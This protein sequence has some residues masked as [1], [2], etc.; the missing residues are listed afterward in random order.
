MHS[1]H[2]RDR[3]LTVFGRKPVLEALR[4][5]N[6]DVHQLLLARTA[7]GDFVEQILSAAR[8]RGLKVRRADPKQVSKLSRHPKQDQG[9]AMDVVAQHMRSLEQWLA[10]GSA[11][12]GTLLLLD[13]LTTPANIG[14]LLR[15]AVAVGID[16]IIIPRAGSPEVGPLVIKASAGL[17]FRAPILRCTTSHAAAAALSDAGW[18]LIGLRGEGAEDLYA[19][20]FSGPTVWV[21]GNE[22]HGVS[23]A[24]GA[25]ITRW[26]RI[27]MA[28]G[29]ESLNVATAGA[30]VLFELLRRQQSNSATTGA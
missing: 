20:S 3:F 14:I 4:D 18:P 24:V 30:V 5:P 19:G 21:L 25:H 13:G 22:T 17:A 16:G 26:V 23:A 9:V 10:E 15:T 7:K 27:P 28:E 2:P 8:D 6:L 11:P 29:V 1:S 12:M